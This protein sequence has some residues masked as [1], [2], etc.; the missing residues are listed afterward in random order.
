MSTLILFLPPARPGAA[1]EYSY[2]LT[3]DGHTATRHALA[4]A[5]L[6][7]EPSRPGAEVVA[8][9]PA[10]ALSWQRVQLPP[11]LPLGTGQQ[12]PRLRSVLDGLLEDRLLDDA[13][14]LHF[15]IQPDARSGAPLWVAVCDRTWLREHLQALE[16]AGRRV[17]RVVPEFA[18]G[19]T[20]SG[21]A[22][23]CA[24][25]TPDEAFVVLTGQGP[26]HGVA[27][28]PLTP[29]ALV[30]ARAGNVNNNSTVDADAENEPLVIRAEPAVAALAE[31]LFDQRV[32]LSTASE[33][34]LDAARGA[35]D[36]AQFDLAS[37]GSTRALR[38]VGG[39]ISAALN[40]PQWRAARW[41]AALLVVAHLVGLN[42]WAWQERQ[43]LATKQNSVR[44]VLT[45]TFPKVQVVVDAPVQMERELALLRQAAGSVS[46]RDLEPLLAA[47][48][49]ALPTLAAS[50][51]ARLP[52]GIDYTPGTLRLRGMAITP[53]E[54]TA[55]S[56]RL[57]AAGYRARLDDGSL[58][59]SAQ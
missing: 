5:A 25:G 9:V 39:A 1:T 35:W 29:M 40:A 36:L 33:R 14:Q 57:Q 27:V 38:K 32:T 22:E 37:T 54:E 55:L 56:T 17:A 51:N 19:P 12:T 41:G 52:T 16:A 31:R 46:A 50:P 13:A 15:A 26:D 53:E 11:G 49:A 4:P 58:V 43:T 48:G 45:Q 28:M 2:T 34:A 3:A 59:L 8:V 7:P 10:R 30:L 21:H 23:L 24:L 47:A 42:A 20:A 44:S 6:L 18:P